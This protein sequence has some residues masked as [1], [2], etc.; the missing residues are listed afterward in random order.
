LCRHEKGEG[1]PLPRNL[2]RS[3]T[4][5]RFRP[6]ERKKGTAGYSVSVL[7]YFAFSVAIASLPAS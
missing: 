2:Y 7:A 3:V 6:C 1:H 4:S 5:G